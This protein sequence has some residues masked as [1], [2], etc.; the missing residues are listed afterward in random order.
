[1]D[2]TRRILD[3]RERQA[4]EDWKLA[5][6]L[7]TYAIDVL[8][9]AWIRDPDSGEVKPSLPP[10]EIKALAGTLIDLQ[11]MQRLALG[12]SSEN[13]GFPLQGVSAG[14]AQMPT[15]NVTFAKPEPEP[16]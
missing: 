6:R 8:Q 5:E 14:G 2:L 13:V 15:I 16:Q 9:Y 4:I 3:W 7:R 1:M 10:S 12:L 11:K